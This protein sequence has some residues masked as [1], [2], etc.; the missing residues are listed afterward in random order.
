MATPLMPSED[1]IAGRRT[2]LGLSLR[3]ARPEDIP[4]QVTYTGRQLASLACATT[5]D[6]QAWLSTVAGLDVVGRIL[7][8][9]DRADLLPELAGVAE[10]LVAVA[11][12]QQAWPSAIRRLHQ[13]G[14]AAQEGNYAWAIDGPGIGW[15]WRAPQQTTTD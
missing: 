7:P 2:I 15:T 5:F 8:L 4:E 3:L 9:V 13:L 14:E 10:D 1:L 12:D 6:D 11:E